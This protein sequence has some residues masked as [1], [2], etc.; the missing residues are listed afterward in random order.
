MGL[1]SAVGFLPVVLV[2]VGVAVAVG[3]WAWSLRR[4]RAMEAAY[5]RV[6]RDHGLRPTDRPLGMTDGWLSQLELLPRGDR[7]CSA[8]WGM[9][10]EVEVSLGGTPVTASCAAFEWWWEDR[11]TRSSGTG[12][13]RTTWHRR[14]AVVAAV[15]L[16]APWLLPRV[17]V[18]REGLFARMGIGGRG[19]FQVESEEFNK[20]YD[21]RVR[22]RQRAIRLFDADFQQQLLGRF[23]GTAFEL[24][25]DLALV[26]VDTDEGRLKVSGFG[27]GAR[28]GGTT[29]LAGLFDRSGDRVG[30]DLAVIPALPGARHRA[31][32]LLEAM[33]AAWWRA[34]EAGPA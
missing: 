18:Q 31:V 9:E 21:V 8:V 10:G 13:A 32:A 15:R 1:F 5:R 6:C 26:V 29:G 12:G 14:A 24:A 30:T 19:D 22:D 3:V 34:V 27:T 2:L 23:D 4:L 16:P 17:R 28:R 11:Q 20:R 33:P 7:D 25:G